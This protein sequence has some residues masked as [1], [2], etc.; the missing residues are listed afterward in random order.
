MPNPIFLN[1][2]IKDFLSRSNAVKL[3]LCFKIITKSV[4]LCQNEEKSGSK[5]CNVITK[6]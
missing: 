6:T 1:Q 4:C 2:F 3:A 5:R